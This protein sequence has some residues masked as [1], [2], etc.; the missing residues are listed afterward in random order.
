MWMLPMAEKLHKRKNFSREAHCIILLHKF[1]LQL[2]N[3]IYFSV[4]TPFG[5]FFFLYILQ[6]D[7]N[8]AEKLRKKKEKVGFSFVLKVR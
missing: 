8:L 2:F 6:M 5:H 3:Y 4:K 7:F 1:A